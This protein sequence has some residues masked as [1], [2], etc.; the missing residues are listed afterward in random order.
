MADVVTLNYT[1]QRSSHFQILPRLHST[2]TIIPKFRNDIS[3]S[4]YHLQAP[5]L[6]T[7]PLNTLVFRLNLLIRTHSS[8][9]RPSPSNCA[10]KSFWQTTPNLHP[11]QKASSVQSV[12]P[13][14]LH[15]LLDRR[16]NRLSLRHSRLSQSRS[17]PHPALRPQAL[18]PHAQSLIQVPRPVQ[19]T[20][21]W[22]FRPSKDQRRVEEGY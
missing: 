16:T 18:F 4:I 15:P 21:P 5:R 3:A 22:S 14:R 20:T 7:L 19:R 17:T 11:Q 8:L 6:D 13:R 10:T 2:S 1:A 12:T 9:E